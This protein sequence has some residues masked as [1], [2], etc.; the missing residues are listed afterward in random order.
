[1]LKMHKKLKSKNLHTSFS[2]I[3]RLVE[4]SRLNAQ[5]QEKL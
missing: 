3:M 2:A 1:M 5:Q 4:E